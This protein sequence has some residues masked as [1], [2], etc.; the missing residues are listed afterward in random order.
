MCCACE[1]EIGQLRERLSEL[2]HEI[3]VTQ[4]RGQELKSE[5]DRHESRVQFN[6]ER[7]AE[8]ASQNTKAMSDISEAEERRGFAENELASVKE[9]MAVSEATL[10]THREELQTRQAALQ[11]V[12]RRFAPGRNNCVAQSDAFAA[13]QDLTRVRNE[14]NALDLQKQGNVVR[15]EKL[16]SEKI[17]LEEERSSLEARLERSRR[18]LRRTSSA[19]PPRAVRWSSGRRG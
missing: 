18:T 13:A 5:I 9:R 4:Q 1:D 12:E 19:W 3:S 16:S 6:E 14:I 11:Q 10:A 7:L 2:E 15:L 17:Q 8:F